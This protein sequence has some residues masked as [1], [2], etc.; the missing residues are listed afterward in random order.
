M[1]LCCV[2]WAKALRCIVPSSLFVGERRIFLFFFFF[3]CDKRTFLLVSHK[4]AW[5]V[6]TGVRVGT[7][8][9]TVAI[10]QTEEGR[11]TE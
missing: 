8:Y 6:Q 4:A 3:F 11:K 9:N 10:W 5:Q 2:S 7:K 1:T